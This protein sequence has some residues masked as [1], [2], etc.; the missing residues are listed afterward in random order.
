MKVR[1]NEYT[2]CIVVLTFGNVWVMFI[3]WRRGVVGL[4]LQSSVNLS[5]R[6]FPCVSGK[7]SIPPSEPRRRAF[8]SRP[9]AP[10]CFTSVNDILSNST[11]V[12]PNYVKN[13][14]FNRYIIAMC[15]YFRTRRR[16]C[17]VVFEHPWKHFSFSEMSSASFTSLLR[18]WSRKM[19]RGAAASICTLCI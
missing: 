13:K 7:R 15:Y 17:G 4:C 11:F 8:G 1:S 2:I 12:P 5:A 14:N 19:S 3:C 9:A 16:I 18:Q 6:V 10:G